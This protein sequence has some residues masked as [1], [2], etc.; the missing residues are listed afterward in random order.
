MRTVAFAVFC[1]L[2]WSA[3]PAGAQ[4]VTTSG[5]TGI[6]K[7]TQGAVVPG[8]N[9]VAVHEPSGTTYDAVTQADGRFFIQGMRV[10]GPYKI[11]ATITGFSSES[12]NNVMLSLGVA[13]DLEFTLKVAAVAE[14]IT[15]TA[16]SDPVFSSTHTGAATAVLREDLEILPTVS[17]RI[18]DLTRLSP[19]YT[20]SGTFSGQDNRMNNITVDGSY[21]N[22]SFGLGGQPGDRTGVAP[23]SL[24]A[25]EQVQVAVAPFDVR[26]G[27]FVGAGVNTVTRSGA[28]TF[29]GSAYYRYHNDSYVGT[30]AAGQTV[31]P[32]T[33]KTTTGGEWFG[34][35]IKK[36]KLFF[37][38]SFE[39][40][41]DSRPLTTF[42]ANPGGA[43]ATGNVTRVLASDLDSLSSFL[44][45]KL[46]Y[47]TGPYQG[48]TKATPAKPFLVKGDYN[49]N[50]GNKVTFRYNQLSSST[51]VNLSSSSSLGFGRQTFSNQFL[52]FQGSNYTILENIH[53]GIAEWNSVIGGGMSNN[54]IAGYT[55]QDESRGQLG[56]LFPFVDIL[57][58]GNAYTSFGSEPFTPDNLLL[59]HTFQAQDSFTLFRNNHTV[60]F[61]GAFEKYHSDNSFY[62]GLQSAYVYNSLADFLTDANDFLAHPTRTTSPVTLR[63]FQVRYSNIPGSTTPPFQALDVSY[64]SVY[65]QDEWRPKTNLTITAGVRVDVAKFG[66]TAFDNPN[67]DA[68]TFL[69]QGGNPVH[70]NT[71]ALPKTS[72]LWSPRVGFNYDLTGDQKTQ[73]RGGTGVFTGKPAYVWIS[74]QIGNTGMLTGFIQATN[75]T[76][77]PF[78]PN[79]DAYK[80][81]PTGTPPASADVAVT[82]PNFKFPQT[83]R[84]NIGLDR[85]IGWGMTATGEFIYNRDVNG[86]AYINANLPAAQTVFGGSDGR[87][88]Y[89]SN[90]I[91]NA[92]GNQVV[93]NIVLLNQSIGRSWLAAASVIKPVTHGFAF[94]GGY[95]YGVSRNTVDPGS[96]ACGIVDEQSDRHGSEQSAARLLRQLRR[97]A[98]LFRAFLHAPVLRLRR[99]DD[100]RVLGHA[101][102]HQQLERQHQLHFLRRRERRCGDGQRLDLYPAE[103]FGDELQAAR[104]HR[105][106]HAV[107]RRRAGRGIRSLHSTGR[108]SA[109]PSRG[110]RAARR[111]VLSA[112]LT[113]GSEHHPGSLPQPRRPPAFR[114][115]ASR[116]HELR[117]P[118]ESQLGRRA[119]DHPEP[120]SHQSVDGCPG[121]AYL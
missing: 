94:K 87:P 92:T 36:N 116:H 66:N 91:N 83:W 65:G 41:Q 5:I 120:H 86:M 25:I 119:V 64:V 113:D 67:V 20:G 30:D 47:T 32:G 10:G 45:S 59:Y 63:E 34:G 117:Q 40:Q 48:I 44:G 13:Q 103:H 73:L 57:A 74:N 56:T 81:G 22:N 72:P 54:L 71:G 26:E 18:N 107:H 76:A 46:N 7:D 78:N 95:S 37:F 82:D 112:G 104:E 55:K 80:P 109:K 70:Y 98:V 11:T 19:E 14:M 39:D 106:R 4:G 31:N 23:I 90:R 9:V 53:S 111:G 60:T 115:A 96:I 52:N 114:S 21:F 12:R 85:R 97:T 15:V 118:A 102:Q 27:N 100:R 84:T 61:G 105:R 62:P 1:A 6:V 42:V 99:D 110:V 38:E 101:R 89:T 121:A 43:P 8:A 16:H 93:E 49:I 17:G 33:F 28:N 24:E 29:A 51:D 35:P 108:L 79:P 50:S 77:F 88:R 75:T 69:D 58:A 3:S 2:L 68:L